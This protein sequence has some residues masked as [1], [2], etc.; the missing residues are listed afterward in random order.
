LD[1]P[2]DYEAHAIDCLAL[3]QGTIKFPDSASILLGM[4]QAW[5]KLAQAARERDKA[6]GTGGSGRA[7]G[8]AAAHDRGDHNGESQ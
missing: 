2:H 7:A 8:L 6:I 1:K 3:A 4:A 5:L